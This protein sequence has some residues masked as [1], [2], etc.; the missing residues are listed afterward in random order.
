[1]RL[2]PLHET[3]VQPAPKS[4]LAVTGLF[5]YEGQKQI[6]INININVKSFPAEAGSTCLLR[7]HCRTGFSREEAGMT[8][9][10]F[11][12]NALRV[13]AVNREIVA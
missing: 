13:G 10:I 11:L 12:G 9:I 2:G 8:T 7:T 3:S 4:R 5:A 6:N 1:M